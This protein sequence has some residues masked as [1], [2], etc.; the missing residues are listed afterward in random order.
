MIYI[1]TIIHIR[2][3]FDRI[4]HSYPH[5][6]DPVRKQ[7]RK[8]SRASD[9][10]DAAR[11]RPRP[12]DDAVTASDPL[13]RWKHRREHSDGGRVGDEIVCLKRTLVLYGWGDEILGHVFWNKDTKKDTFSIVLTKDLDRKPNAKAWWFD[14]LFSTMKKYPQ[15][16]GGEQWEG[17]K[18]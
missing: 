14:M 17:V 16:T 9:P 7:H 1:Y 8:I 15:Q 4:Y 18:R 3:D 5:N 2:I 12:L 11:G 10:G 6:W 13:S